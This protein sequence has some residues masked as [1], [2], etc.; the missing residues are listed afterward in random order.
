MGFVGPFSEKDRGLSPWPPE[1][2]KQAERLA[3]SRDGESLGKLSPKEID[4]LLHELEVQQFELEMQNQELRRVRDEL[5]A[6]R[7]HAMDLYDEAPVGYLT[8]D[9]E[10]RILLANRE[11]GRLLG[12]EPEALRNQRLA[13]R[14]APARLAAM[15]LHLQEVVVGSGEH[16][17]QLLLDEGQ[18]QERWVLMRTVRVA[19]PDR[20]FV[21]ARSTLTD[22]SELKAQQRELAYLNACLED[23][24]RER[25]RLAEDR[26]DQLRRMADQLSR[27]EQAERQRLAQWL[28]DDLQQL[29]AGARLHADI[30]CHRVHDTPEH[31]LARKVVDLLNQA[32]TESRST[33]HQ[34][35]P[36][37]LQEQGLGA[38]M[39]WLART[40]RDK[41]KLEV[42]VRVDADAEPPDAHDRALLYSAVRELLFNIHKHAGVDAARVEMRGTEAGAVEVVVSDDGTGFDPTSLDDPSRGRGVGLFGIRERLTLVGGSMGIAS[43]IGS[44]TR[45][46]LRL[47]ARQAP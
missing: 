22:I 45:I 18:E 27:T 17:V 5:E 28:H 19:G 24:V 11:A 1:L 7:R 41:H 3:S 34:L 14:V 15:L 39:W 23:K 9:A 32:V 2:R 25:T 30:L 16:E 47:P 33:S 21:E 37:I 6:S 13:G 38:A 40:Y 10:G 43:R 20:T 36:P 29:L 12:G 26:S 35:C 31:S 4:R 44:G 42:E 46:T 8:L